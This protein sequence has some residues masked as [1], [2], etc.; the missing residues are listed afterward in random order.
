MDASGYLWV[1]LSRG[2]TEPRHLAAVAIARSAHKATTHSYVLAEFL[3]LAKSRRFDRRAA[4]RF[5]DGVHQ[6]PNIKI[7]YVDEQLH[8]EAIALLGQ[9]LD[10]SWSLCDAVSFVLMR[11]IGLAEALTTDHH[12][13][14]A[15][16]I[17]LLAP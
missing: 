12:F 11:R 13:E 6:E 8:L 17:R 2:D 3:A 16:V 15:G 10:K 5:L 14:Q 4:L 1:T 9:R 7:V